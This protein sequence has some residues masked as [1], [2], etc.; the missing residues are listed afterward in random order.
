MLPH[1]R[2][3]AGF[4][5]L[6]Y[7]VATGMLRPKRGR[8]EPRDF[9]PPWLRPPEIPDPDSRQLEAY[10]QGMVNANDQHANSGR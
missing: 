10:L 8:F 2:I 9:L 1:D 3:D 5:Q 7:Y 6:S 4:A